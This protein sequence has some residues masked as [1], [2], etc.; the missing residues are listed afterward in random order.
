MK[1]KHFS[2][3]AAI[4]LPN[5]A[6]RVARQRRTSREQGEDTTG[7]NRKAPRLLVPRVGNRPPVRVSREAT[8]PY[9]ARIASDLEKETAVA[10]EDVETADSMW[11]DFIGMAAIRRERG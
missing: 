9:S 11:G 7:A 2:R 10:G 1:I 3:N 5:A 6:G 8:G 4:R